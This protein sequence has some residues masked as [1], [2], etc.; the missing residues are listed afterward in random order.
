MF[1]FSF[2]MGMFDYKFKINLILWNLDLGTLESRN[3][4]FMQF[5]FELYKI[6]EYS[7]KL[8]GFIEFIFSRWIYVL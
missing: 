4:R 1:F 6:M 8:F 5:L 2:I 7:C 3:P